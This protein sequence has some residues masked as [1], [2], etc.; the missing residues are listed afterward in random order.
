[1]VINLRT[2][3]THTLEQMLA[4]LRDELGRFK[5]LDRPGLLECIGEIKLELEGRDG[6]TD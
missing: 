4:V 6:S 5:T 1:M 2:L 3:S